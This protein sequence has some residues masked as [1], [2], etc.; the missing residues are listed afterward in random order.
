MRVEVDNAEDPLCADGIDDDGFEQGFAHFR[1]QKRVIDR[2]ANG[3]ARE[4]RRRLRS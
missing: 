1:P 4:E 3:P 2:L